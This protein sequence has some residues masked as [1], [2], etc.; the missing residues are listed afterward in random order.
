[1]SEIVMPKFG[2]TMT[3]GLITAWHRKPGEPVKAGELLFEVET[4][5]VTNEVE[6]PSDG[7]LEE[8]LFPEGSVVA[9]GLPIDVAVYRRDTLKADLNYRITREEPYFAD[10]R[11]RW[12]RAL[13]EAQVNIPAPPYW[14]A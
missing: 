14:S 10:L 13:R 1:M 12:S 3:E 4:E 11:E 8:I 5:K 9:V 7:V 2:L 6:A